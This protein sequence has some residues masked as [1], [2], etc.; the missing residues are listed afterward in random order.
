MSLIPGTS[1]VS[2]A[3]LATLSLILTNSTSP[4]SAFLNGKSCVERT[5]VVL[6]IATTLYFFGSLVVADTFG[7]FFLDKM[8][9]SHACFFLT[10]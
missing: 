2:R 8:F 9:Y 6:I 1:N 5:L 10:S 3:F 4:L 7:F